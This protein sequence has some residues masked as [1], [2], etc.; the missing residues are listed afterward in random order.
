MRRLVIVL[1]AVAILIAPGVASADPPTKEQVRQLLSGYES[2]PGREVWRRFGED[3]LLVLAALYDDPSQPAYVRLRA[4]SVAAH[5][6][7]A[8][9]RT[10]LLA[11]AR[12][13]GQ[14]DLFTREAV[15]ALGR[16]FGDRATTDIAPFLASSELVVREAA[17]RA[18]GTI[19]SARAK[20]L[21]RRRAVIE[22]DAHVRAAIERALRSTR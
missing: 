9:A 18:L 4:V 7:I 13:P 21:L 20:D 17:V 15:L 3:T 12:A 8:A 6:P 10:F 5:Y 19:G 16:A 14:S 1:S 22:P 2:V 11:V